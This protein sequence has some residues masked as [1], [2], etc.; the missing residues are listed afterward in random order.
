MND[1][2]LVTSVVMMET[3]WESRRKDLL[4]LMTPFVLYAISQESS[5]G[6][7]INIDHVIGYMVDNY[8]YEDI[9]ELIVKKII[10]RNP[11]KSIKRKQKKYF[12]AK[13]L[14]KFALDF[15]KRRDESN[16]KVDRIGKQ[17][18]AY[19]QSH[20]KR[21]KQ[22]FN[23]RESI[24]RLQDFFSRYGLFVGTDKLEQQV[25][26]SPKE[27]EI[28]YYISRYI[29]DNKKENTV[30]YNDILD[31]VKGY[32]LRTV[33]YLQPENENIMSANYLDV[34]F[35]YDTPILLNLLGYQS[36][37]EEREANALHGQLKKK[38]AQCYYFCHAATEMNNILSAYQ[39]SLKSG[40]YTG[41]TL[42]GLD[43]KKYTA[44]GVE[45]LKDNWK[46]QLK[47]SFQIEERDIPKYTEKEDGTVNEKEVLDEKEL[48]SCILKQAK[49]YKKENVERDVDSVLAIHRL[50]KNNECNNIES[51]R[52]IFVTN[53]YDLAVS[54]NNYYRRNVNKKAFPIAI[55]S[56]E[57]A[58]IVWVKNG[59]TANLPE[60]QLLT[61]A[62]AALQPMPELLNKFSEV[63]EQMQEEG[64]VTSEEVAALRTNH[65]VHREL[66]KETFGDESLTN[67]HTIM[68]IKQTY[69]KGII[70]NF[71]RDNEYK[72]KQDLYEKVQAQ[73]LESGKK[74]K[75][76]LLKGLRNGSKVISLI[77]IILCLV[78][79]IKT[80]G[81][82][83]WNIFF[84]IVLII[85]AISLY[86]VCKARGKFWDIIL[87][88][89]A[90][91]YETFIIE[92]KKKEYL[93]LLEN[94][95]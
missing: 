76:N 83:S 26:L 59:S 64:K 27:H 84:V 58:A 14:D 46:K 1:T 50:R 22:T 66:W 81:T 86:D 70:D 90:N 16:V 36:E 51:A 54:V 12:L 39:Y 32:F 5:V 10:N 78:A 21:W 20:C 53:N 34:A 42:E 93:A 3:M 29:F 69:D 33:L 91:R 40:Q 8:G 65:Y 73:A 17:L 47:D 23:D 62:Y 74:A 85:T 4:D 52:A 24:L 18:S 63:L 89:I 94:E 15:D 82:F 49:S 92:K 7:E 87:V 25:K 77:I 37:E 71:K 11:Y 75:T 60:I 55:T 6:D 43:R 38:K 68:K 30:Q 44:S 2:L 19:L 95:K 80:W 28:D 56:S 88:R 13:S 72:Q 31:L 48:T 41:R 67:E 35:Y 79:T 45:R 61:N 57:L 9:P